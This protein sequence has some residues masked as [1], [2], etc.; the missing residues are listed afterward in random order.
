MKK[1]SYHSSAKYGEAFFCIEKAFLQ[2]NFESH[3]HDFN[4]LVFIFGGSGIHEIDNEKYSIKKGDVFVIKGNSQHSF[5]NVDNLQ[6]INIMFYEENLIDFAD[7]K[8]M[9]G[10]W[11]LF[12]NQPCFGKKEYLT[13]SD[14]H[15]NH[16]LQLCL[17][18]Y[19][20]FKEKKAGYR[21]VCLANFY[22]V[23]VFL[24][25]LSQNY[26]IAHNQFY[27]RLGEVLSYIEL[28]FAEDIS[29]Q[30]LADICYLSKRH[31]SRKF[32]E[33]FCET[34]LSYIQNLRIKHAK[35]MLVQSDINIAQISSLCGFPD[36][37]YFSRAFKKQTSLSPRE[38]RHIIHIDN[39]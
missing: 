11:T 22:Q 23:I 27:Y 9:S 20:E 26:P 5:T 31:F 14:E 25:R 6:I 33:V 34:P 28:N 29:I 38:W 10:F 24:S 39:Q 17:Y 8:T 3:T 35:N 19:K 30:Q 1:Y 21:T 4:E 15:Y 36:S 37:N 13:L 12:I 7:Y 32:H 2:E 18:M 16:F